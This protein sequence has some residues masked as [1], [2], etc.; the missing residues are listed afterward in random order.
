MAVTRGY[1]RHAGP[2]HPP[3]RPLLDGI[4]ETWKAWRATLTVRKG[5]NVR[6]CQLTAGKARQARGGDLWMAHS[7]PCYAQY[8]QA[9]GS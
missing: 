6:R 5:L 3:P 8:A 2:F 4:G 1:N 7:V 9:N